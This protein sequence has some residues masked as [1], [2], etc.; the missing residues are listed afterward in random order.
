MSRR[1]TNASATEFIHVGF[2][3]FKANAGHV[4]VS[5]KPS[6]HDDH[7]HVVEFQNTGPNTAMVPSAFLALCSAVL[8]KPV[9]WPMASV[10]HIP[11]IPGELFAKFQISFYADPTD[12]AFKALGM[13]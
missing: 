8:G 1:G 5:I 10:T 6:D 11:S 4:S 13:E 3:H 9:Q 12:A 2:D 7:L